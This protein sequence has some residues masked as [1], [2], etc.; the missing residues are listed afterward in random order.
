MDRVK[1]E[2]IHF[3]SGINSRLRIFSFLIMCITIPTIFYD[4]RSV[5]NKFEAQMYTLRK[6]SDYLMLQNIWEFYHMFKEAG[7]ITAIDTAH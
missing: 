7:G 1:G 3:W 5:A 6:Y 4:L 2:E